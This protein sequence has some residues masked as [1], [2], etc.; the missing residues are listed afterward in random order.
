MYDIIYNILES[1]FELMKGKKKNYFYDENNQ[2]VATIDKNSITMFYSFPKYDRD[3]WNH[4]GK[5][6]VSFIKNFNFDG[7]V[8][9]A[10]YIKGL[11][12]TCNDIKIHKDYAVFDTHNIEITENQKQR[13]FNMLS[14]KDKCKFLEK[15][16][17]KIKDAYLE[18]VR[19]YESNGQLGNCGTLMS[20]CGRVTF[21]ICGLIKIKNCIS[22]DYVYKTNINENET[23]LN[24]I[25]LN[26]RKETDYNTIYIYHR[27]KETWH[28]N[29]GYDT[30][31]SDR[32]R[33]YVQSKKNQVIS[34]DAINSNVSILLTDYIKEQISN[35]STKSECSSLNSKKLLMAK[36]IKEC[37]TQFES[38][39]NCAMIAVDYDI[40]NSIFENQDLQQKKIVKVKK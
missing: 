24:L 27:R 37:L 25:S 30:A 33:K 20:S 13:K 6:A 34:K 31:G 40:I 9:D 36:K 38:K 18:G 5:V 2:L 4:N 21:D 29:K 17:F 35:I 14:N 19:L 39:C 15:K 3:I 7:Y 22:A 32:V 16:G 28:F 1:K 11:C 23:P 26:K 12:G 8:C 10:I